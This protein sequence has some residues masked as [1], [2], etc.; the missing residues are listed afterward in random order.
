MKRHEI[1]QSFLDNIFKISKRFRT[2]TV[3][4]T[5]EQ[6]ILYYLFATVYTWFKDLFYVLAFKLHISQLRVLSTGSWSW[7][8]V[9]KFANNQ[10]QEGIYWWTTM[11]F[12]KNHF[13]LL[14]AVTSLYE[15]ILSWLYYFIYFFISFFLSLF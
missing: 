2:A 10:L 4:N 3:K 5:R 14:L 7:V 9:N 13:F 12:K 1:F 15:N 6:L 8:L 11:F